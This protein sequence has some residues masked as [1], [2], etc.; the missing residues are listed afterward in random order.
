[1][2]L[3]GPLISKEAPAIRRATAARMLAIM[4]RFA[5]VGGQFIAFCKSAP[6]VELN[7]MAVAPDEAIG[8]A[9]MVDEPQ[10]LVV[11]GIERPPI[12][13]FDNRD[14]LMKLRPLP[15]RAM[16]HYFARHLADLPPCRYGLESI[17]A[18]AI[19]TARRGCDLVANSQS[20]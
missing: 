13:K 1:M 6:G 9:R 14:A 5:V 7:A 16:R 15:R 20:L 2:L 19:N 18:G 4:M 3:E 10:Q 17:D 11:G 8:I 12:F